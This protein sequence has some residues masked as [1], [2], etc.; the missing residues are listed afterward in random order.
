MPPLCGTSRP[1]AKPCGTCFPFRFHSQPRSFFPGAARTTSQLPDP[2]PT[3]ART[4][5][6]LIDTVESVENLVVMFR[7][8]ARPFV[9]DLDDSGSNAAVGLYRALRLSQVSL[10]LPRSFGYTAGDEVIVCY[11]G[12]WPLRQPVHRVAWP[13][14]GGRIGPSAWRVPGQ[15]HQRERAGHA[16]LGAVSMSFIPT[17]PRP[18][19][20]EYQADRAR[21]ASGANPAADSARDLQRELELAKS[22]SRFH[23]AAVGSLYLNGIGT[24]T[25]HTEAMAWLRKAALAG[26]ARAQSD[27]G[28]L[29]AA[30]L[31]TAPDAAEAVKWYRQAATQ[32]LPRAQ[33]ALASCCHRGEGVAKDPNEALRWLRRAA[34]IGDPQ[35]QWSLGGCYLEGNLAK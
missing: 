13:R 10:A 25:N 1:V 2:G 32:E 14:G 33:Y 29:Y 18:A 9:G 23:Q 16:S 28:S 21:K 8:D 20:W 12:C 27:L 3:H 24:T 19:R 17:G 4:R 34:E 6:E 22:G 5:A 30:G 35:A 11:D 7:A 15:S 31:G 26:E